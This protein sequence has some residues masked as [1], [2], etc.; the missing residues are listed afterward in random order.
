M[1][2]KARVLT[3]LA[4]TFVV[5]SSAFSGFASAQEADEKVVFTVGTTSDMKSLSPYGAC[6]T[7]EYEVFFQIYDMLLNF[8]RETL[9][10]AP[11]LAESWES[12]DDGKTWTFHIREDAT[13]SDGEP[14]TAHDIKDSL[15]FTVK[16][17][18]AFATYLPFDPK[19][20]TPDDYT[21]IW[22]SDKPTVSPEAPPWVP[23]L[24]EHIWGNGRFKTL[25]EAKQFE[26]Y[27]P[28]GSGP[29]RLVEWKEGQFIRL[30]ANKD[31]WGGA[32]NIDEIV[33][34]IF[35]NQEAMVQALRKGE[36]DFAEDLAPTLWDSLK[37]VPGVTTFESDAVYFYNLAFGLWKPSQKGYYGENPT[38]HPSLQDLEVRK[39]I[40]HA[41]NKQDLVDRALFGHG[42]VGSTVVL[43]NNPYHVEP[44][45]GTEYEW[46][47]PRANQILDD[48]GYEDAD[49]DGVREMPGGGNPLKYEFLVLTDYTYSVSSGKLIKGWLNQIGIDVDIKPV[50]TN[51]A[52]TAWYA[53]DYDAYVWGWGP[54]PD[55]DFILS[56]FTTGS[57]DVW[58]DGC[59][60]NK[61]YD[62]LYAQQRTTGNKEDR[63]ELISQMQQMIYEEIPEVVLFYQADLQA[64]RSDR[65][66]G[67]LPNPSPQGPIWYQYG[68]YSS[69]NIR[70]VGGAGETAAES[71][72][73][74]PPMV[75]VAVIGGVVIVIGIVM[76][77]RRR[78]SD[79]DRA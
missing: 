77:V 55:P 8:D 61:E 23:I 71:Q 38:N 65:W 28:V 30:E 18:G 64:Y 24:P 59:Y 70:P 5:T 2:R 1:L 14:V 34:R 72:A 75:W 39:A 29:F 42:S 67:F 50:T 46:D 15:K 57:C 63:R 52:Y 11:G 31:Y 49:G 12:S 9:E 44:E 58:S 62:N 41:I 68:P 13:W 54:D 45:P 22:K 17:G 35:D 73:G 21:L 79:E 74:I 56:I 47:I 53:H 19:F 76:A 37:G 27:P 4:I 60:S 40:A 25:K 6:C 48:A 3:A 10:A 7:A 16:N 43:P 32:P 69:M 78:S 33:Y 26:N 36:I 20:E 66:T 51:Q